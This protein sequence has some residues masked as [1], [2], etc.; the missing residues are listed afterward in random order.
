MKRIIVA[1]VAAL[2]LTVPTAASADAGDV[3]IDAAQVKMTCPTPVVSCVNDQVALAF[4]L[5]QTGVN[6]AKA[7]VDFVVYTVSR[8]PNI[9]AVCYAIYGRPCTTL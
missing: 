6:L 1:A 7:Y 2:A 8:P 9:N 3:R 5:A 4:A